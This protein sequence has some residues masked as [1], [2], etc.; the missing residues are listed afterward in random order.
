MS[1]GDECSTKQLCGSAG[2]RKSRGAGLDQDVP[3]SIVH[4][5][6]GLVVAVAVVAEIAANARLVR[7]LVC[8][9]SIVQWTQMLAGKSTSNL[10]AARTTAMHGERRCRCQ[11]PREARA[12][13]LV[14]QSDAERNA[15]GPN[16]QA[17][18]GF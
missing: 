2:V 15:A 10:I 8:R 9:R 17:V 1:P 7:S 16:G 5:A 14:W 13:L 6:S 18:N 11:A 3:L 4:S 12:S